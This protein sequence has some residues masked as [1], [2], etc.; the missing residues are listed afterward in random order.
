MDMTLYDFV[1]MAIDN[2]YDCYVWDNEKE[3]NV[4]DGTIDDI[5]DELL[6]MPFTSWEIEGGKIG[7]NI[8]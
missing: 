5:P 7:L 3:E 8:N 1:N 2:Y 6:S 4:F